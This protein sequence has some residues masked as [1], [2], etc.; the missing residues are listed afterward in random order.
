LVNP[1]TTNESVNPGG[2]E[3]A[4]AIPALLSASTDRTTPETVHNESFPNF[5]GFLDLI[6]TPTAV[7]LVKCWA[8]QM[9]GKLSVG[10]YRRY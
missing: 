3:A 4:D 8:I 7:S 6:E 9:S 1:A 5:I 10:V 2:T